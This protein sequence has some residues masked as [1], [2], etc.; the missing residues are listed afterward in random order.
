MGQVRRLKL[1]HRELLL[2]CRCAPPSSQ[3]CLFVFKIHLFY[4]YE[5]LPIRVFVNYVYA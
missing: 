2:K 4:M 1:I 5:C 3:A